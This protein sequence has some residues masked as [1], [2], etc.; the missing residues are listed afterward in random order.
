[1]P[2]NEHSPRQPLSAKAAHRVLFARSCTLLVLLETERA[3][4]RN[5]RLPLFLAVVLAMPFFG[6]AQQPGP[7]RRDA[8]LPRILHWS[9]DL[10]RRDAYE[11]AE[12]QLYAG[13]R[14]P[15]GGD[16]ARSFKASREQDGQYQGFYPISSQAITPRL[17]VYYLALEYEKAPHFMKFVLYRTPDGW[18]LLQHPSDVLL[19]AAEAINAGWSASMQEGM[20]P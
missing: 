20:H 4:M 6:L 2:E 7:E 15:P 11:E 19:D 10:L 14:L 8:E 5:F 13:S 1:M 17:R 12:R 9:L 16:L 3:L 18:A